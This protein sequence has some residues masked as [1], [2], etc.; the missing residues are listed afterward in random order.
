MRL[1]VVV[2]NADIRLILARFARADG[3][4]QVVGQ[5]E[6]GIQAAALVA[7]QRPDVAIVDVRVPRRD[8]IATI[9]HLRAARPHIG[10]VMYSANSRQIEDVLDLGADAWHTQGDPVT[11]VLD[12]AAM[13]GAVAQLG[14][15]GDG[16]T[17]PN[18]DG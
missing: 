18:W 15:A 9:G 1:V 14:P 4:F 2:D 17:L 13:I 8:G 7:D 5:A 3:R 10:I 6:D 12:S 11:S 16:S